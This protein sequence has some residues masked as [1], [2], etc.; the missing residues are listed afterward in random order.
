MNIFMNAQAK[1]RS[2]WLELLRLPNL[3][4]VPGDVVAGFAI[5]WPGHGGDPDHL[6]AAIIA[7]LLFYAAGLII[8]DLVDEARDRVE[9]PQRPIPSGRVTRTAARNA[10]GVLLGLALALL[11]YCSLV[12]L[13]AGV[14][15]GGLIFAYNVW[16]RRDRLAGVLIMGLCRGGSVGIGVAAISADAFLYPLTIGVMGWWVLYI[17][18]VSW[19]AAREMKR[20]S[21]GWERWL[22]LVVTAG[23]AAWLLGQAEG[24]STQQFSRAVLTFSFVAVIAWQSAVRLKMKIAKY[25]PPVIGWLISALIPM[26]AGVL[27][28]Y[29]REPWMLFA[30]LLL[31]FCWPLNRWLAKSFAPS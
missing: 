12:L 3:L 15:L 22:P 29:A 30:A 9:R 14:V 16:A 28:L 8:N 10:A 20:G 21:Y 24:V 27:V 19:L 25:H 23:G 6:L 26:Q 5:A 7:A 2:G 17:A 13:A 18:V 11:A 1:D 31:L 4:T